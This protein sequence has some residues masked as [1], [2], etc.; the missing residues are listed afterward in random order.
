MAASRLGA[1]GPE[2]YVHPM[3]EGAPIQVAERADGTVLY[4]VPFVATSLPPVFSRDLGGAWEASR[5]AASG[6][7]PGTAR[8]FRFASSGVMALSDRDARCWAAAVDRTTGLGTAYGVSLLLRLL[9]LVDLL[10]RASWLR[11][12][13]LA[14]PATRGRRGAAE[15]SPVLLRAV[16]ACQMTGDARLDETRLR[17]ALASTGVA[18]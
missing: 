6:D 2:G 17:Q 3:A 5:A 1:D 9:S 18:A 7:R 10:A 16:S 4:D 15:L 12:S 13:G 8:L 14:G 11:D